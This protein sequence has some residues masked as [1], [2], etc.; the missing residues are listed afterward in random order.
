MGEV[1]PESTASR[2]IFVRIITFFRQVVAEMKKVVYPTR[3]ELKIYFAVVIVF[4][5][6]VMAYVGVL[7]LLF[8]FLASL[9]FK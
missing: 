4:V 1:M 6:L 3:E 8:G 5:I 9:V 7:D 2:N